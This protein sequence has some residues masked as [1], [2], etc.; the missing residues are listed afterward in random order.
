LLI[1]APEFLDRSGQRPHRLVDLCLI[2]SEDLGWA[3]KRV[4]DPSLHFALLAQDA[5]EL[6]V[7]HLVTTLVGD[8]TVS[9]CG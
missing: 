6:I 2:L 9:A 5:P 3:T 1:L 8:E 4:G 7:V